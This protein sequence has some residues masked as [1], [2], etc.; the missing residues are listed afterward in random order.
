VTRGAQDVECERG[1]AAGFT[2][3]GSTITIQ[4]SWGKEMKATDT[5]EAE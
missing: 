1:G 2:D 4:K 3:A 5:G